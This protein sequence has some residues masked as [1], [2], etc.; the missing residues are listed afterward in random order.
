[1]GG[2]AVYASGGATWVQGVEAVGRF[3]ALRRWGGIGLADFAGAGEIYG[4]PNRH[5]LSLRIQAGREEQALYHE[6]A[7]LFAAHVIPEDVWYVIP[8][9]VV[10][11]K[12]GGLMLCPVE[13][14]EDVR[15]H[16]ESYREAWSLLRP[17]GSDSKPRDGGA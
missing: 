1:M 6:E 11:K 4:L 13:R 3:V 12:K 8:A 2:V 10:L 14:L 17:P 5:G 9:S 16:Y 15:C 7:R